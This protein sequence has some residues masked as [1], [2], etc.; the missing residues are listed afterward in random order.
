MNSTDIEN[1][2]LKNINDTNLKVL[3]N[4]HKFTEL[5]DT[6]EVSIKIKIQNHISELNMM[7]NTID[8]DIKIFRIIC[9][10]TI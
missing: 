9:E 4:L 3:T 7:K 6:I 2:K 5:L 1:N 8:D 10:N